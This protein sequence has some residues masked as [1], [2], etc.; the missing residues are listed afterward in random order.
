[1]FK[2]PLNSTLTS[3]VY[4]LFLNKGLKKKIKKEKKK[5]WISQHIM[6]ELHFGQSFFKLSLSILECQKEEPNNVLVEHRIWKSIFRKKIEFDSNVSTE[7]AV[8][9]CSE[10]LGQ[11]LPLWTV[12]WEMAVS[13]YQLSRI[14]F[15]SKGQP[16]RNIQGQNGISA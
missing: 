2:N 11:L 4:R 5:S 7:P 14:P 3:I 13:S 9:S 6:P 12:G 16:S 1:M 8:W 10:L 15:F